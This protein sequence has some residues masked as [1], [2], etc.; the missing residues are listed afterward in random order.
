LHEFYLSMNFKDDR[1]QVSKDASTKLARMKALAQLA[2]LQEARR[3]V[4]DAIAPFN[5]CGTGPAFYC[6]HPITGS[7]GSYRSLSEM[8]GPEQSFFG[9]QT[10]TRMRNS[11]F[12]SSIE[13]MSNFYVDQLV[14][15][16]PS[17]PFRLGGHSVGAMIALEMAHQ[18]LERGRKVDLLVVIDGEIFN[19]GSKMS[20]T[21]PIYW[22][23]F[24][25]NIPAWVRDF[26]LIEFDINGFYRTVRTKVKLS[27]S[28]LGNCATGKKSTG[29]PVEGFIDLRNFTP[30]HT[31]Y[32]KTLF[33]TQYKYLPKPYFGKALVCIAKTQPLTHLREIRRPWHKVS[34]GAE[35]V[36][37]K[38]VTHTSMIRAPDGK[39][40]ADLLLQRLTD[41]SLRDRVGTL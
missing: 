7:V 37:F 26:L 12:P 9:I 4:I 6:V 34:P 10:P 36:T 8:L 1:I 38:G 33:E 27:W 41:Q 17:G 25:A 28:N 32:I 16:Q 3:N 20:A 24:L 15:F 39:P 19:T 13:A 14:A 2:F 18:L 29:H 35:F 40:L 23:R 5:D 30:E 22:L 31:S 21:N 11:R